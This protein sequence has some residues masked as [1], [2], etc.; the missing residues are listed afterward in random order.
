MTD[1]SQSH[2]INSM[3]LQLG[4]HINGSVHFKALYLFD[5]GR[6]FFYKTYIFIVWG[7]HFVCCLY[8]HSFICSY[9]I[10]GS[11]MVNEVK[12]DTQAPES[13]NGTLLCQQT[14]CILR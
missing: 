9:K 12:D 5:K 13:Y 4:N 6:I 1:N 10:A 8:I 11:K 14:E 7:K 2:M 3:A